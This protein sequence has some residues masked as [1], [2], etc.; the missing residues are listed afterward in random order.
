MKLP[1]LSGSVSRTIFSARPSGAMP[2]GGGVAVRGTGRV[3]ALEGAEVPCDCYV[4]GIL[5]GTAQC[6]TGKGCTWNSTTGM[7]VCDPM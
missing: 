6:A 2:P 5:K 3:F 7:C 4:N 1:N